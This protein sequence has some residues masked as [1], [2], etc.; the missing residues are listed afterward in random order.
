M[1]QESVC[2]CSQSHMKTRIQFVFLLLILTA[3]WLPLAFGQGPSRPY[4]IEIHAGD[5]VYRPGTK[6]VL[7]L[8]SPEVRVIIQNQGSNSSARFI[9]KKLTISSPRNVGSSQPI[10]VFEIPEKD[11]SNFPVSSGL[12]QSPTSLTFT[13]E[14]IT[15]IRSGKYKSWN[16][17][18]RERTF[19]IQYV[20]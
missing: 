3:G 4:N 1:L 19:T 8:G 11:G 5:S 9:A 6:I 15:E 16:V 17:P 2:P 7:P 12:N 20:R 18:L 10:A 13:L 14:G